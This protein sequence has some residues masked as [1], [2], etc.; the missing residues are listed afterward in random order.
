MTNIV[1]RLEAGSTWFNLLPGDNVFTYEADELPE[2]LQCTF[3]INNQFE[4]V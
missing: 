4:G 2:N 1:G 3:I